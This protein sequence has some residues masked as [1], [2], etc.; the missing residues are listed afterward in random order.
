MT[1]KKIK[2]SS[3]ILHWIW[4]FSLGMCIVF[5]FFLFMW[6]Y[7]ERVSN[8]MTSDLDHSPLGYQYWYVLSQ[9]CT[10]LKNNDDLFCHNKNS[11]NSF[12]TLASISCMNIWPA[13]LSMKTLFFIIVTFVVQHQSSDLNLRQNTLT[14]TVVFVNKMW[15]VHFEWS[16]DVI[17]NSN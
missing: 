14:C 7:H 2:R 15:N 8:I 16:D 1:I 3:I 10:I 13:I 17:Y 6:S 11:K 5:W 9:M 12:D 4:H